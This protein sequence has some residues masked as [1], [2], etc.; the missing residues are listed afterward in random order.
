MHSVDG[1]DRSGPESPSD[2]SDL[3]DDVPLAT[4]R[5]HQLTA[6]ISHGKNLHPTGHEDEDVCGRLSLG[7]HR[8]TGREH[9]D[10]AESG[11]RVLVIF[12]EQSPESL[13]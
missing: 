4:Q 12:R 6:V 8:G 2:A 7:A 5:Q 11:E 3:S 1:F 9:P 13:S 10:P